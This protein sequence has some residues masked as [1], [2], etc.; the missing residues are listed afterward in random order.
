M[1][2]GG[3]GKKH[4]FQSFRCAGKGHISDDDND[5]KQK[6]R[7]H[8][9]LAGFFNAGNSF[10]TYAYSTCHKDQVPEHAFRTVCDEDI[11]ICGCLKGC[12]I[13]E[14]ILQDPAADHAV[15]T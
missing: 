9:N 8:H 2:F 1:L 5:Q 7:R 12:G 13:A 6:K 10:Q 3:A 11:E 4:K 14:N 15:I